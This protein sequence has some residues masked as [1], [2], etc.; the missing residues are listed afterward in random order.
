MRKSVKKRKLYLKLF[1]LT[2]GIFIWLYVISSAQ[3]E[4]DKIVPITYK[5]KSNKAIRTNVPTE[6][7]FRVKGPR[8]FVRKLL[9]RKDRINLDTRE[10]NAGRN[11]QY[12]INI[13]KHK[14]KLPLGIELLDYS[15]RNIKFKTEK[16]ISKTVPISLNLE[17]RL[18]EKFN[19]STLNYSPRKV[20]ITGAKSVIRSLSKVETVLIEDIDTKNIN[21]VEYQLEK[22]GSNVIMDKS[23]ILLNYTAPVNKT[24][25][26]ISKIPIIFQSTRLIK[27]RSAT[28]VNIK[29]S[30]DQKLKNNI[31]KES[32]QVFANVPNS[33]KSNVVIDLIL[34]L[35]LGMELIE[36][37]PKKVSIK[38]E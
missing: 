9:E 25:F 15:P 12:S 11:S 19:L 31:S 8:L 4:L 10:M 24:E 28:F 23:S 17:S 6:V 22:S 16:K 29:I 5:V 2:F 33:G 3:V 32:I 38:L 36:L 34:E 18:R 14:I 21:P 37:Y 27:S 30:G 26:T 7:I 20:Q 13:D 1:S 35:P